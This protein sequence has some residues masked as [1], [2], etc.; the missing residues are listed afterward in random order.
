MLSTELCC[1]PRPPP[2]QEYLASPIANKYEFSI[3]S[4]HSFSFLPHL[5]QNLV[6]FGLK[7]ENLR[8]TFSFSGIEDE[9]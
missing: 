3:I 8:K 4:I 5:K 2:K 9:F 1:N 6:S 7:T